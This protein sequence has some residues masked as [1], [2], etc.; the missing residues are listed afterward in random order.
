M[1]HVMINN[2]N[3]F[4]YNHTLNRGRKHFCRYCLQVFSTEK[5][6]KCHFKDCFKID[7][8]KMFKMPKKSEYV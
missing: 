7:G 6:L 4:M 5:V 1:Y 3:T 8:K 2:F